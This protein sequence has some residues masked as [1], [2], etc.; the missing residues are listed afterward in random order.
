MALNI[1]GKI[2]DY[3]ASGVA[4]QPDR[5]LTEKDDGS[6]EGTVTFECD[7][8]FAGNLPQKGAQHPD[9]PRCELYSRDVT[10][11]RLGK[12]RMVGSYFGIVAPQTDPVLTSSGDADRLPIVLHPK[13]E[14]DLGGDPLNP[15]NGALFDQETGEFLG[16]FET[17]NS[18]LGVE[19]FFQASCQVSLTYWTRKVPTLKKLNKIYPSVEGF[20]KP[21]GCKDFLLTGSP[22]RQVGT[23]YQVTENYLGSGPNGWNPKIYS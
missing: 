1:H 6:I 21:E 7:R 3:Y 5:K 4:M 15:K 20:K 10:Y 14:S 17:G 18:L 16:F 23:H 12:V 9:D 22:Y 13:F 11:L 19:Y 2:S 8:A